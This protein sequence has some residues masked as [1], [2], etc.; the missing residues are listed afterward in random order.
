MS[1]KK[2]LRIIKHLPLYVPPASD[3]K[4]ATATEPA[5]EVISSPPKDE[6]PT[7][8]PGLAV[9]WWKHPKKNW[10]YATPWGQKIFGVLTPMENVMAE[11]HSHHFPPLGVIKLQMYDTKTPVGQQI[12]FQ[13]IRAH[14]PHLS[15]DE[16]KLKMMQTPFGM[17]YYS[18]ARAWDKYSGSSEY[19]EVTEK[20]TTDQ[21]EGKL[22][23]TT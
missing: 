22:E 3:P 16:M 12:A 18:R 15:P 10:P 2:T 17:R 21:I 11:N 23:Q 5:W 13:K 1:W 8:P 19:V 14:M 9:Y 4:M 6:L 20:P 7:P